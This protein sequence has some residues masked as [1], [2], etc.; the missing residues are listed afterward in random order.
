M[1]NYDIKG[2]TKSWKVNKENH[3]ANIIETSLQNFDL[4]L[5]FFNFFIVQRDNYL[6]R[7]DFRFWSFCFCPTHFAVC[8]ENKVYK[9]KSDQRRLYTLSMYTASKGDLTKNPVQDSA[10]LD[11][12]LSRQC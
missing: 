9:Q 6:L 8:K 11:S 3:V 2:H 1:K 10:Q 12:V 5:F 4:Y 7:F